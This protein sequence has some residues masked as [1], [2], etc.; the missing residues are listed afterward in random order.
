MFGNL[1][2]F[3]TGLTICVVLAMLLVSENPIITFIIKW[4]IIL[5]IGIILGIG[6]IGLVV[7]G[8]Y[9]LFIEPFKKEVE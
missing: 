7:Y 2:A 6:L 1:L 5:P 3:I 8:F 9:W 4:L